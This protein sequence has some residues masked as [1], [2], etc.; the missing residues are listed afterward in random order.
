MKELEC[1]LGHDEWVG[2]WEE[3]DVEGWEE[4]REKETL[5]LLFASLV[6]LQVFYVNTHM[7]K[8]TKL[9]DERSKNYT[10]NTLS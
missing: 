1:V 5:S 2:E 3:D 8:K 10:T 6:V 9:C 4:G 7:A